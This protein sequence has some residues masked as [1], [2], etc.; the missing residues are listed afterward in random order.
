G[1]APGLGESLDNR[2]ISQDLPQLWV[3]KAEDVAPKQ[4]GRRLAGEDRRLVRRRLR[5]ARNREGRV[6]RMQAPAAERLTGAVLK[7][8]EQES[9]PCKRVDFRL[10]RADAHP[11]DK[12]QRYPHRLIFPRTTGCLAPVAGGT[13]CGVPERHSLASKAKQAASLACSGKPSDESN[14]TGIGDKRRR[15]APISCGFRLPPPET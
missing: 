9:L 13:F 4:P 14:R 12:K 10:A 6:H 1:A 11:V 5:P 15:S 2:S 3:G 7:L 8:R